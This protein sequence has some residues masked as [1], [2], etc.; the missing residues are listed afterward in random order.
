MRRFLVDDFKYGY[1][2]G[3]K[4]LGIA[5]LEIFD[6]SELIEKKIEIVEILK[7]LK[8]LHK[9][10]FVFL[11]MPDM[12]TGKSYFIL[13]NKKLQNLLERKLRVRFKNNLGIRK[14]ILRKE[15]ES[16]LNLKIK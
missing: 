12:K 6:A 9:L 7:E 13:E 4:E 10:D 11:N 14:V 15:I 8:E 3:N 2:L 5:Q 16:A 1:I